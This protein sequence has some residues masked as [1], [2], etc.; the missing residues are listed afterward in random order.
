MKNDI[1]VSL[2]A[3]ELYADF[4]R[5]HGELQKYWHSPMYCKRQPGGY[6]EVC[7]NIHRGDFF[8]CGNTSQVGHVYNK[9]TTIQRG[10]D[11]EH[12]KPSPAG[13]GGNYLSYYIG[14]DI[15]GH[16]H[17][18][19]HD[20]FISGGYFLWLPTIERLMFSGFFQ[21]AEELRLVW[22]R[23]I[24]SYNADLVLALRGL[25]REQDKS[26]PP[27]FCEMASGN[28]MIKSHS[29]QCIA[30]RDILAKIEGATS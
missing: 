28:P 2:F 26:M 25:N 16:W 14:G 13:Q 17:N 24:N 9:I 11:R 5:Q 19:T 23:I 12:Q 27:C 22:I 6:M 8:G 3:N 4:I 30:A 18:P 20:D 21:Q 29:R 15:G 7:S 1:F 10:L